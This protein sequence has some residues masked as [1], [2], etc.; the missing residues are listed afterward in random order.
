M[1]PQDEVPRP[2]LVRTASRHAYVAKC[3][4]MDERTGEVHVDPASL[5][6]EL[7]QLRG[8]AVTAQGGGS[9][10]GAQHRQRRVLPRIFQNS[11]FQYFSPASFPKHEPP[12]DGTP[13]VAFLGRSNTGKSSL[14]NA[15]SAAIRRGGG[16][17]ASQR[18]A[19]S[20]GGELARTSKRPGRTQSVNYFGVVPHAAPRHPASARVYLVDLPGF[21]YAAAPG[22]NVDAWQENTQ[23]FLRA[24][25]AA[26]DGG[27]DGVRPWPARRAEGTRPRVDRAGST[28]PLKRLYLLM[29]S[30]LSDPT[31][32]DLTVMGW[33]DDYAI[34]YTIVLTK[35]DGAR[36]AN[37]VKLTNQM[38]MRYHSLS[39]GASHGED[40]EEAEGAVYMDPVVH[41]TS[42]KEG[43]G[44]EELL[45]SVENNMSTEDDEY[46]GEN[47]L[48]DDDEIEWEEE[49]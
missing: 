48:S 43:S 45:L 40:G 37:C 44:L 7:V 8:D 14:I 35:V 28:A 24:R 31:K 15:L 4:V 6:E 21:G 5:F 11:S 18:T 12:R 9:K 29:D 32:I 26:D 42:S 23:D 1:P 27:G 46:E 16:G 30:R 13:E 47:P 3:A 39:M 2:F 34:P 10:E 19:A 20:G 25:A 36:R 38:C 49:A 17:G 33:C 22:E 41:W